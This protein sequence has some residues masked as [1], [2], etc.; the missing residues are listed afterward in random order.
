VTH[1]LSKS[2]IQ[3][4]IKKVT[5]S[6][7]WPA[8]LLALRRKLKLDQDQMATELGV[9]REWVSR[10]ERERGKFSTYVKEKIDRLENANS[11]QLGDMES[12]SSMN[13]SQAVY[14]G[15]RIITPSEFQ[16]GPANQPERQTIEALFTKYLDVAE[17]VPGG[18]GHAWVQVKLHLKIDDLEKLIE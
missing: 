2:Q 17:Q 18:L 6:I 5:S 3:T 4:K 13:E 7:D 1:G 10:L 15:G 8:R 14:G 11:H 12:R 9:G 16:A